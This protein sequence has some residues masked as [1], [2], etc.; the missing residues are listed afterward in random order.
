MVVGGG[1]D[2]VLAEL[3]WEFRRNWGGGLVGV[4]FGLGRGAWR[5]LGIINNLRMRV[6]SIY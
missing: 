5:G 1:W 6:P 2:E 3:G 4:A